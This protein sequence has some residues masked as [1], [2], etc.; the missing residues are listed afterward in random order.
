MVVVEM[1]MT[2]L[3]SNYWHLPLVQSL[4]VGIGSGVLFLLSIAVLLRYFAKRKAH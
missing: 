4:M 2:G 3:C 1:V